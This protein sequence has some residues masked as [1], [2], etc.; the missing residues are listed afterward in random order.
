MI[1]DF[2]YNE[3]FLP[4]MEFGIGIAAPFSEKARSAF[5]GR[6]A[7]DRRLE[8]ALNRAPRNKKRILL[9]SPSV[10]EFLQGRAVLE[11]LL[12]RHSEFIAIATHFS[13]SAEKIVA[14][15]ER[16]AARLLLPFDTKKNVCRF[17]DIAKPDAI[18]FSRADVWP[19]LAKEAKNRAI[20]TALVAGTL[21]ENAGRLNPFVMK[22][23]LDGIKNLDLIAAI[24][25]D[26]AARFIRHG[27]SP[28]RVESTGDPRF[29]Q[30]WN[31]AR[32]VNESE[33]LFSGLPNKSP[34]LVAGSTWPKDEKVVIK[35]FAQVRKII[36]SAKLIIAPHE[37]SQSRIADLTKIFSGYGF[38]AAPLSDV[39]S[40]DTQS[41]DVVIVDRVGVL[42]KL[43][44]MGSAAFVGGSFV[45]RVH[46]IM[47]PA[48]MGIPVIVGPKHKNAREAELL[49][50]A[51]GGFCV[52]N[53][54]EMAQIL[55]RLFR[56]DDL[57]LKAGRA[58]M[59]F[60]EANLGAASRT[61]RLIESRLT[62]LFTQP[63]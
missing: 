11:E 1:I 4:A 42:A 22:I 20:P 35:A 40:Q 54:E 43:Y 13:P 34:T 9:H 38:A 26:D 63:I 41:P 30:T 51:G 50:K 12:K 59:Q 58:A 16:A 2:L 44:K 3:L 29:D 52:R 55:I 21:P 53:G 18:I 24:S 47:E 5:E 62:N 61:A 6:I 10:G 48:C 49:I 31:R 36:S 28:N 60:V 23:A 8:D 17:L 19:N 39:D 46:N 32:S 45:R 37:P 15:Y 56:D 57:R 7:W 14:G 25:Q 33:A 27:V